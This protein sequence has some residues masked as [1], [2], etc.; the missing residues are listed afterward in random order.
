MLDPGDF[1]CNLLKRITRF[2]DQELYGLSDGWLVGELE[3]N[4]G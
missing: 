4:G 3:S 2:S 1:V